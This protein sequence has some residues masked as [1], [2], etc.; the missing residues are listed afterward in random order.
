MRLIPSLLAVAVALP[1]AA[2]PPTPESHF[3]HRIGQDRILLDWGKVVSY[4]RA[5]EQSSDRIRVEDI[6][7]SVQGRT[8]IAA[9]ISDPE[10]L[11]NLP[12]YQQIQK[13]LAD[14][15]K[16]T[17]AEA[18]KLV[19]QGK[20]VVAITCSVHATEVAS[21]HTAVEFAYRMLTEDRPKFKAILG[22]VIFILVPSLNP[23]G[24]DIVTQW[25]RRTLGTPHE[26]T[27]PPE[28]YHHYVGHDNNRDWYIF[29][30]PETRN[31]IER[32]HN[33]WHPQI[34][35]DVHQMGATAARIFVPPWMD[36]IDPNIDPLIVQLCNMIGMGM[37]ADITAAG[38]T[39]VTVNAVYDFWTPGR[40]Y[41]AYHGGMRILSESAS[42]RLATPVTVRREQL[43]AGQGYDGKQTSWNH[44]EPWAGGEWRLRDIIDYQSLAWESCLWQA[45]S[46]RED[47]LRNFY[48]ILKRASE[49][50]SPY[51]FVIPQSQ[52]DPGSSKKLL[53]T[54]AFGLIEVERA[55]EA[56]QAD[57]KSYAAGSY[58]IRMQQPFSNYAKTLLEKQVYPDL[59]L[60]PGGP[61]KRPYDVTAHTLPL[62]MGVHVETIRDKFQ[63]TLSSAREFTF[64]V[65]EP[66]PEGAL[67]ISD[68]DTWREVNKAW[69]NARPVARDEAGHF[70]I[71][72]PATGGM[73]PVRKPRIALYRSHVPGM[74]EGWTR[75]IFDTFGFAYTRLYNKEILE[76]NLR[77]RF[78][79]ILFP[80]QRASS[81][82]SGYA[83]NSMPAEYTGGLGEKGAQALKEFAEQ[84][85]TL[86][87]L[88]DSSEYAASHL[89]IS[90][91]N[92][93]Q[94]VSSRDFYS[95][96]SLLS[97]T[98]DDKH[99]LTRGMPK[100][101]TVWSEGSPAWDVPEGSAHKV[102]ARYPQSNLLASGW[103]LG[104][105][106]LAGRA[107][108]VEAPMGS[109]RVILFGMRPQYRAQS[110]QNF[111]LLF[112]ALLG[113]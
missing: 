67:P 70:Y 83:A 23:D 45:A 28:L 76:G 2:V 24:V 93:V 14:A 64:R 19:V 52:L 15:R 85:G 59:R 92:S 49:R 60:Y 96:G 84:G 91:K 53:E 9:Y 17:P 55:S 66:A 102:I 56:F 4:F 68:I 41:Q 82:H 65:S 73:K 38:K 110:Y 107:A 106:F 113:Y 77:K 69:N 71:N 80:D 43:S 95:P 112:N 34:V 27:A 88:N 13:R 11:R 37:A 75:W 32:V 20:T 5:L 90:L 100:D 99:P 47:L 63:A 26:G 62:L 46:R 61:P 97:V 3:G 54:L 31:A 1:L 72:R 98:L 57:G 50:V 111:K 48:Q 89:G 29:S 36:P 86:V 40:H 39:G 79:A 16:T 81:I 44:L 22:N 18:E 101:I 21:T 58:V 105:K 51:A 10:T 108:L 30:Q 87:F 12:R 94:G 33:A 74:D 25:Y 6:G 109:G 42:A 8:M 35:Y 7:K 78:D 103:L 104:E